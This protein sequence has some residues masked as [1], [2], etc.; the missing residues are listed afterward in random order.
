MKMPAAMARIPIIIASPEKLKLNNAISPVRMSQIDNNRKPILLRM[1]CMGVLLS[2]LKEG[3]ASGPV[4]LVTR[5]NGYVN[6]ISVTPFP[7]Q[8]DAGLQLFFFCE[9]KDPDQPPDEAPDCLRQGKKGTRSVSIR[10]VIVS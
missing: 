6:M 4:T 9:R 5:Q 10:F 3:R 2:Y 1:M 7:A 8:I